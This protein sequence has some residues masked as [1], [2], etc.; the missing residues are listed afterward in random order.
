MGKDETLLDREIAEPDGAERYKEEAALFLKL[1]RE[2]RERRARLSADLGGKYGRA[3]AKE[4]VADS[5]KKGF[6]YGGMA[7]AYRDILDLM[8]GYDPSPEKGM[9]K[10][11]S[12]A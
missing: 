12:G 11:V 3:L 10:E 6:F 5:K 4:S 8:Q 1:L 9:E 7:C 2:E